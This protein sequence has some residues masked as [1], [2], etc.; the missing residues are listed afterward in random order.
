[1]VKC[2]N[3]ASRML[4]MLRFGKLVGLPCRFSDVKSQPRSPAGAWLDTTRRPP[5]FLLTELKQRLAR[6]TA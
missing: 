3:T 1:M 5:G 4:D 2:P 6:E